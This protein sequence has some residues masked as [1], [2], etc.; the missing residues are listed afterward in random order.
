MSRLL[1][2]ILFL[3]VVFIAFKVIALLLPL[4][5][6]IAVIGVGATLYLRSASPSDRQ[7]MIRSAR[8]FLR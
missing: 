8:R 1:P 2:L 4:L 5:L 6:L 7:R 3:V